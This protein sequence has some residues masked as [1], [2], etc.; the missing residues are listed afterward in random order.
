[1]KRKRVVSQS[2]VKRLGLQLVFT[3]AVSQSV[4]NR[5]PV[6]QSVVKRPMIIGLQKI[7]IDSIMSINLISVENTDES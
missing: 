3:V 2:V 5:I 1:M 7:I 6:S 4:V